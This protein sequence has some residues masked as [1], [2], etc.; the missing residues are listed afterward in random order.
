[1]AEEESKTAT[2]EYWRDRWK[3]GNTGW[4]RE[5]VNKYLIKYV[6]ELTGGRSNLRIFVPLCGKSVDMLWL[7]A[8]C[9]LRN[10]TLRN[11][12]KRN[13]ICTLRN[14]NLYFAK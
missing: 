6:N 13:E 14:E 12:T 4:H 7:A 11:E 2:A 3:E 8:Y 5:E 9:S 10:G 1:M